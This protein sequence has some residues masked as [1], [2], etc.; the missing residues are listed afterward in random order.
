MKR[1]I[2]M[3]LCLVYL[4]ACS[5][6]AAVPPTPVVSPPSQSTFTPLPSTLTPV[7]STFTPPPSA[8]APTSDAPTRAAG[9]STEAPKIQKLVQVVVIVRGSTQSVPELEAG[10]HAVVEAT[11][12][13]IQRTLLYNL[14]GAQVG[15]T[16]MK[17]ENAPI[18]Q[19]RACILLS[20]NGCD[21]GAWQ[22]FQKTLTREIQ[23]DWLG[24]RQVYVFAE[25]RD[26]SGA[27]IPSAAVYQNDAYTATEFFLTIKSKIP[28]NATL[29]KLPSPVLT[30]LAATRTVQP[31]TGAVLIERGICCAGGKAGSKKLL[32][33]EFTAASPTGRVTEMR[34]QP[35][36]CV[37]DAA[38]LQASWEPFQ[39]SKTYEAT[40]ALNWVGWTINVQYRD[41]GGHVS[42]IYCDD[43]SLEGAP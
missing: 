34:V 6:A 14:E 40:L 19:M 28:P 7:P 5:P 9:V 11:F 12:T 38:Q 25:F 41:E 36:S 21:P 13:P 15:S 4:T 8:A 33:V 18:Q 2:L 16:L 32:N 42:P 23:V 31:V 27:A 10:S 22:P 39:I 43:I 24:S 26:G 35:G 30:A 1:T 17:L 3:V 29:D 37:K 20:G